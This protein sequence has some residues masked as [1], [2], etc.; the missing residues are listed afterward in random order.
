M[1]VR[2][3]RKCVVGRCYLIGL[4]KMVLFCVCEKRRGR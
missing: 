2:A 4:C 1:A 3:E